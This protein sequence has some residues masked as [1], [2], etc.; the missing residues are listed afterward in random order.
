MTGQVFHPGHHELHGITVV[1]ETHGPRTYVGRFDSEDQQG[2]HLLDAGV[3]EATAGA[4][5]RDDYLSRSA[6]FG[7]RAE[8]KH[9][10]VPAHEVAK[11][12]RLGEL[13]Q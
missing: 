1:I 12:T 4:P 10:I 7:V 9:L 5:S 2:L 13:A 8:H 11:I 6:K 3:H